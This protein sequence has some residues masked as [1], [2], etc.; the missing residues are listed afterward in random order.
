MSFAQCVQ[1][2][3]MWEELQR[4]VNLVQQ[5]APHLGVWSGCVL[6]RMV[7][8]GSMNQILHCHVW[9]SYWDIYKEWTWI[10]TFNGLF[11]LLC[12]RYR[13]FITVCVQSLYC[14]TI[15]CPGPPENITVVSPVPP[16]VD[17]LWDQPSTPD[18][19]SFMYLVE[20]LSETSA[21]GDMGT[22]ETLSGL[23]ATTEYVV[24]ITAFTDSTL[25][26]QRS[27]NFT[28]NTIQSKSCYCSTHFPTIQLINSHMYS[29]I[30]PLWILHFFKFI[31]FAITA[32]YVC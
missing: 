22:R 31:L 32:R 2:M 29:I 15:D 3:S 10:Q 6:A 30:C 28:F 14:S 16:N 11:A 20:W 27:V 21:V 25:C 1:S 23:E 17:L 12:N 4:H 8:G 24:T 9:V 18:M 26:P 13:A 5:W 19:W 7:L